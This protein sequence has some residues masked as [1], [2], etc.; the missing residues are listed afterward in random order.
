MI[1]TFLVEET[2][3]IGLQ[4]GYGDGDGNGDGLGY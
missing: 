1:T 2:Q 4:H 3:T